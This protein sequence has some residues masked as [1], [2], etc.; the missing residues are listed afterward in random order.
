MTPDTTLAQ[1]AFL[2]IGVQRA[3]TTWVYECLRAHPDVFLP[4]QKELHY[5]DESYELGASWYASHFPGA[6]C[7]RTLGEITPSYLHIDGVAERIAS[8]LPDIK[9]FVILREPISRARSGFDLF[10]GDFDTDNFTEA[11]SLG[12]PLV[13]R[14]LYSQALEKYFSLF[15]RNQILVLLFDDIM[16]R[17]QYCVEEICAHIGVKMMEP[18]K[19]IGQGTNSVVF[20]NAQRLLNRFGLAS[21]VKIAKQEP[22]NSLIRSGASKVR[23]RKRLSDDGPSAEV[24][25]QF[26][27]DIVKLESLIDRDL[28]G[29]LSKLEQ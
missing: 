29:W 15:E 26:R 20:P 11:C 23:D 9:L 24:R 19:I 2:G 13:Q 16:S 12:S 22:F 14:S 10:K 28:S 18:D 5:F 21:M 4:E 25:A 6:E 7:E 8:D 27:S 3:A 1:P 17:P